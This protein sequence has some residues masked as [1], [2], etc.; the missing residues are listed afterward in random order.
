[1]IIYEYLPNKSLDAFIFDNTKKEL[2][3]WT[4]RFKIIEGIARGL[5]YLHRDSRL[6]IVHRDLKASNILLDGEMNPKISDFGM[7]RIFGGDQNH[8]NTNRVVGT[9]GYMSPEYAMEGLFS[10]KSD[11]YSFGVL[12]LEIISG[13]KNSTFYGTDTHPNL[14]AYAWELLSQ[15]R[16][17][18]L[19]DPSIVS[20]SSQVEVMRCIHVGLL[21]VQDHANDRPTMPNVILMLESESAPRPMPKQPTFSLQRSL[22]NDERLNQDSG[23]YTVNELTITVLNGR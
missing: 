23:G 8:A 7:A 19:I 15:D 10:M 18:E 5:V 3:D 20:S 22:M 16:M 6:R 13:R 21:C 9:Y 12:I 4:T 1:M 17:V 11:V 2:L 14:V